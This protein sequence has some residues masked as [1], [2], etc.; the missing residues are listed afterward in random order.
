[1][2]MVRVASGNGRDAIGENDP[3]LEA[4]L[5]GHVISCLGSAGKKPNMIIRNIYYQNLRV[6]RI[7]KL[8]T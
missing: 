5:F 3:Q 6:G 4:V 1:M 2:G 8:K 7:Q